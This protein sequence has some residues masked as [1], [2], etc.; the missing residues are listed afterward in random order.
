[1]Y[2]ISDE[3]CDRIVIASLKESYEMFNKP[4]YDEGGELLDGDA[5]YLNAIKLVLHYYMTPSEADEW[6]KSIKD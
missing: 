5:D 2:T 4:D 6:E 1:M 3:E